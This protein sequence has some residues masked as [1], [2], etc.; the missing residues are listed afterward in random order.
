MNRTFQTILPPSE[1]LPILLL[2]PHFFPG[3][4]CGL[5][6][7]MI[8][9]RSDRFI[10]SRVAGVVARYST[11]ICT[12]LRPITR[13][14]FAGIKSRQEQHRDSY[15]VIRHGLARPLPILD[16]SVRHIHSIRVLL[17]TCC[18]RKTDFQYDIYK[19]CKIL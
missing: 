19:L 10:A 18:K 5:P 12:M 2:L 15:K 6:A 16:F 14:I 8:P 9:A 3:P 11:T 4:P 17:R 13:Q 7:S 1:R